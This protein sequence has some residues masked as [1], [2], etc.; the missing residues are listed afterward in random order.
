MKRYAVFITGEGEGCDY[1]I[2]CNKTFTVVEAESEDHARDMVLQNYG[3]LNPTNQY[4]IC[5]DKIEVFE[6]T[7][8][9]VFSDLA[10]KAKKVYKDSLRKQKEDKERQEFERLKKKYGEQ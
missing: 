8:S 7:N 9:W 5:I 6:F 2:G 10:E 4:D 1:T 3:Q